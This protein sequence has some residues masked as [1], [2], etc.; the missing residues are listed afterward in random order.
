MPHHLGEIGRV[1]ARCA[2]DNCGHPV[3][4]VIVADLGPIETRLARIERLVKREG[5]EI[6]AD[7]DTL[8]ADFDTYKG[9]VTAALGG[10]KTTV[11]ELR[12]ELAAAGTVVPPAVQAKLDALDADIEAADAALS[13]AP[14]EPAPTDEA[15]AE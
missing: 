3:T 7:I 4:I 2:A 10:L 5:A 9:D 15:P 8:T 14:T 12:D 1:E 11:Q 13:P 6:M